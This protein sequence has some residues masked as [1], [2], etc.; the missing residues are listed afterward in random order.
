LIEVFRS[1]SPIL[2]DKEII[3]LG[4]LQLQNKLANKRKDILFWSNLWSTPIQTLR[5]KM[6]FSGEEER[7]KFESSLLQESLGL[8]YPKVRSYWVWPFGEK[9]RKYQLRKKN[10][11][12]EQ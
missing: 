6:R 7:S 9:M 8:E 2:T 3:N 5:K 1:K 11:Q 10:L 12:K 4:S